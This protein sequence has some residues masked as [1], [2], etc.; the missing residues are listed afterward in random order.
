MSSWG[1]V[2]DDFCQ[3][4]GITQNKL[5]DGFA[6]ESDVKSI[7]LHSSVPKLP[8][9]AYISGLRPNGRARVEE[10][11]F[12]AKAIFH[13]ESIDEHLQVEYILFFPSA[14]G[15]QNEI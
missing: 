10:M 5:D 12:R 3:I 4:S 15:L 9:R 11:N 8:Q 1:P 6:N 14:N 13:A 7:I 2:Q